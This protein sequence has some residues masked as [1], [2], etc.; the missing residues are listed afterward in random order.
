MNEIKMYDFI[1]IK[2]SKSYMFVSSID[3][4]GEVSLIGMTLNENKDSIIFYETTASINEIKRLE[5][6][7][8]NLIGPLAQL[9]EN[10]INGTADVYYMSE[11]V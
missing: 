11:A 9:R 1:T 7:F 6:Y 8:V 3:E 4:D 2:G 5:E 10:M